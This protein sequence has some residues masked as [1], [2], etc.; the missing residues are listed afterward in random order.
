MRP[1]RNDWTAEE[2][3]TLMQ[4]REWEVPEGGLLFD[5]V[6]MNLPASAVEFLDVFKGCFDEQRWQEHPL[7]TIHCYTFAKADECNAGGSS[8][9]HTV[10]T[11]EVYCLPD[12]CVVL[13]SKMRGGISEPWHN[14]SA[15]LY[16]VLRSRSNT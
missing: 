4:E 2:V 16:R 7:P 14:S 1:L 9:G 5:H 3:I 12:P 15:G 11:I 13:H 6:V 10:A 8:S